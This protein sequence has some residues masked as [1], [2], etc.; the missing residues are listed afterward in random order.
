[1]K[2]VVYTCGAIAVLLFLNSSLL[3]KSEA[4]RREL[5]KIVGVHLFA[6]GL[7]ILVFATLQRFGVSLWLLYYLITTMYFVTAVITI[8]ES[9]VSVKR[10]NANRR[11]KS[12]NR[13]VPFASF[14]VAAYL[15]NEV[16]II[17]ETIEYILTKVERPKAGLE[18]ILVYNTPSNLP[19]E[20]ELRKLAK[21]YPELRLM[22]V[23]NSESKAENLNWAIQEV[24]GEITAIFDADHSPAPDCLFRAWR[25]LEKEYDVVQGR[26]IIRNSAYNWLT[27]IIAVE[28]ETIYAISHL[29]KSL[30]ADTA[31]FCGTNGF[32]RTE[33]LKQF[34]FEKTMMTEDIDMTFKV[35]L[36]GYKIIHDRSIISKELAPE[37]LL[38]L[39]FQRKR[40]AQGWIQVS[41][42]YQRPVWSSNRL[43][44]R[45]KLYW[46][47]L[48][49][50]R[51]LCHLNAHIFLPILFSFWL[52]KGKIVF[53]FT[54]YIVIILIVTFLSVYI[55][56]W[57]AYKR[58]SQKNP[59]IWYIAYAMFHVLY[60]MVKNAITLV[61][62][63][64]EMMNKRE[65][66][67]TRRTSFSKINF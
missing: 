10:Y 32:W 19:V 8:I 39:W 34:R 20:E 18:V 27:K 29:G 48:L 12:S 17:V 53:T 38:S 21:I 58:K 2:I 60:L 57:V 1:M 61:A 5:N 44:F 51:E 54:G 40:W 55:Q 31:I 47:Y 66:I 13:T 45:Q 35:L 3:L 11:L 26:N 67:V 36:K 25:W 43:N 6:C 4:Q 22:R 59:I 46:T 56:I 15:P 37:K 28:F 14:I 42:R 49:L 23:M 52:V 30:I 24:R 50:W 62:L 33:I 41:L 9:L 16:E 64:D 65:W 63:Y 7:S